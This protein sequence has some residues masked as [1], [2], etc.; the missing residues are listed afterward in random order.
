M[1]DFYVQYG[2]L[3]ASWGRGERSEDVAEGLRALQR[4]A[5]EH[6]LNQAGQ[7]LG[8]IVAGLA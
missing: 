6:R 7:R 3:L 2:R 8:G 4:R 5:G 1:S